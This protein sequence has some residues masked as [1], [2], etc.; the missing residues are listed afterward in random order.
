MEYRIAIPS[1][2]RE[3]ILKENTLK[4]INDVGINHDNIDIFVANKSEEE[5]YKECIPKDMYNEIIVGKLGIG[6]QRTFMRKYY[7][8]GEKI[9][10]LDDDL[11]TFKYLNR[12]NKLSDLKDF[13]K[14]IKLSYKTM[15][16][17]K[18]GLMGIYQM[19]NAFYMTHSINKGL[20]FII[21]YCNFT[22]NSHDLPTLSEVSE[23]YELSI[24][25]YLKYGSVLKWNNIT[26]TNYSRKSSKVKSVVSTEKNFRTKEKLLKRYPKY[27]RQNKKRKYNTFEI[28][29]IKQPNN[30]RIYLRSDMFE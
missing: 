16:K 9:I 11:T 3:S 25:S 17:Y 12:D 24:K 20:Y 15:K 19:D 5:R 2:M 18:T 14:L 29:F 28:D 23:D 27:I 10:M 4:Y 26:A 1:Y 6:K 13:D 22:I 7:D 21:G 30:E 8:V